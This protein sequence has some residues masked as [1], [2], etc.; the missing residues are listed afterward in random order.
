MHGGANVVEN[1][2]HYDVAGRKPYFGAG[3][4]QVSYNIKT[5]YNA[6]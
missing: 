3:D 2:S 4:T 6:H 1:K 5:N